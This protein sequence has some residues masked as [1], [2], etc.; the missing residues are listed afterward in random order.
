MISITRLLLGLDSMPGS[1]FLCAVS[2]HVKH[3]KQNKFSLVRPGI[4]SLN[5]GGGHKFLWTPAGGHIS[6]RSYSNII[7]LSFLCFCKCFCKH[8]YLSTYIYI[9][10]Y[11][12]RTCICDVCVFIKPLT[13]FLLKSMYNVCTPV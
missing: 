1:G 4:G 2:I 7:K 11:A 8:I 12:V 9:Y 13:Y 5:D 3:N 6:L 10:T